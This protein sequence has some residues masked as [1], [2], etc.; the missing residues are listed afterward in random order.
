[1]AKRSTEYEG[2]LSSPHLSPR[3]KEKRSGNVAEEERKKRRRDAPDMETNDGTLPSLLP[4]LPLE[5]ELGEPNHRPHLLVQSPPRPYL[6][7]EKVEGRLSER[8]HGGET[9]E[10]E[11]VRVGFQLL[12][13]KVIESGGGEES[14]EK[15]VDVVNS[16]MGK[17]QSSCW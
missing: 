10:R 9:V 8:R 6:A 16:A 14:D 15:S 17:R 4:D 13:V 7:F 12:L 2:L 3:L 5:I 11:C 1:M